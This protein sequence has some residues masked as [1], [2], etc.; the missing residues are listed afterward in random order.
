MTNDDEFLVTQ[1]QKSERLL[2][3]KDSKGVNYST[4]KQVPQTFVTKGDSQILP[5]I[6]RN[7]LFVF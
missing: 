4:P 7:E 6:D 1:F 5:V 2:L 3:A